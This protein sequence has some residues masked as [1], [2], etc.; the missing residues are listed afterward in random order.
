VELRLRGIGIARST[1]YRAVLKIGRLSLGVELERK[2]NI[3]TAQAAGNDEVSAAGVYE[4]MRNAAE[5]IARYGGTLN[6]LCDFNGCVIAECNALHPYFWFQL[7]A[8][9]A[10]VSEIRCER[11]SFTSK[12]DPQM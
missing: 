11:D 3:G 9:D 10:P 6:F 4:H 5:I 2:C 12:H 8:S 1:S 7:R